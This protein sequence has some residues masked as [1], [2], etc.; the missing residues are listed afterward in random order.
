[1]RR[2]MLSWILTMM[3]VLV[4][5]PV[6]AS[7]EDSVSPPAETTVP[8]TTESVTEVPCLHSETITAYQLMEAEQK[9]MVI[10]TCV[11][12]EIVSQSP[13]ECADT[14][15]D[16]NCDVCLRAITPPEAPRKETEQNPE[17]EPGQQQEPE[18]KAEQEPQPEPEQELRQNSE[19]DPVQGPEEEPEQK[20]K[21][22]DVNAD[23]IID[24]KDAMCILSYVV[25]L[26]KSFDRS[27]ADV[28]GSGTITVVD[29]TII[30]RYAS[31]M[32]Q[33]FPAQT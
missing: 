15:G 28:D 5:T 8:E 14:D 13:A 27:I 1:M 9:H 10:D 32:I 7:A 26:E 30:L 12:G 3:L 33:V 11:C 17:T 22:G 20:Q 24:D 21:L 19:Q 29:A 6:P 23:G 2:R 16:G 25:G 31:G 18:Q 4:M